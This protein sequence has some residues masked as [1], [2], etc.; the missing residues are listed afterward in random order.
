MKLQVVDNFFDNFNLIEKEFK[1]IKL[2]S[3]EQF[4]KNFKNNSNWPGFRS[5]PLYEDNPFLFNL[6]LKEF[7]IKFNWS[8]PIYID[9]YMHLRLYEHQKEDWV[10][11]DSSDLGLIIYLNNNLDSGTNFYLDNQEK[12]DMSIK[13]VKNRCILFDSKINHK[14]SLNFGKDINDGRLTLNGF[15]SL[16]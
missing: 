13:M 1:K 7:K 9:F 10:H 11:K 2:Y 3:L 5:A 6:F 8:L 14:S 12:P 16:K 15:I 4:N